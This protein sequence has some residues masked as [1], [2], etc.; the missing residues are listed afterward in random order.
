MTDE[1]CPIA[2]NIRIYHECE[3]GIEKYVLRNTDW[4]HEPGRVMTNGAHEG[5]IF[6]L[7]RTMDSFSCS[8]LSSAFNIRKNENDLQKTLDWLIYDMVTSF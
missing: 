5:R 7:T 6:I 1:I 8:P 4:H 3:G 2:F